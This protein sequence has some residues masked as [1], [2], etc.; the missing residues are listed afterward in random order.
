[1][2]RTYRAPLYKYAYRG[3]LLNLNSPREYVVDCDIDL[4]YGD[5]PSF[6]EWRALRRSEAECV[7]R[8]LPRYWRSFLHRLERRRSKALL[9]LGIEPPARNVAVSEAANRYW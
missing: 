4:Q 8:S 6:K 7:G 3:R 9:D 1:M 5:A 2:A